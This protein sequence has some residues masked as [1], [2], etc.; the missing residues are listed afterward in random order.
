M[1]LLLC[2]LFLRAAGVVSS[3]TPALSPL[4]SAEDMGS[5]SAVT[6]AAIRKR[7][8]EVE[9]ILPLGIIGFS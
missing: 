7:V 2:I 9:S 3:G 6:A 1:A 5:D 8:A 4:R